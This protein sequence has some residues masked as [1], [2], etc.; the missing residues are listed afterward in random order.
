LHAHETEKRI[1]SRNYSQTILEAHR[2][3]HHSGFTS[4]VEKTS[5]HTQTIE[6]GPRIEVTLYF[7]Q[8]VV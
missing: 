2:A 7:S 5:L 1:I 4:Q 8:R 3:H 6:R